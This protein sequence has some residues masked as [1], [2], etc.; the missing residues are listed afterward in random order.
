MASCDDI[1]GL[2]LARVEGESGRELLGCT[3]PVSWDSGTR[4][5]PIG[6]AL[7]GVGLVAARLPLAAAAPIESSVVRDARRAASWSVAL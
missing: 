5:K 3:A 1:D 4:R 7:V 2:L 6:S